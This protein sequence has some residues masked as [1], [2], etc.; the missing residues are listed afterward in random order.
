[1]DGYEL[2]RRLRELGDS[3]PRLIAVTGYGHSSDREKSRDA[4]FELHLVKPIELTVVQE[5]LA[6]LA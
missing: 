3:P 4:G 6:K 1:M 5:A 2:A